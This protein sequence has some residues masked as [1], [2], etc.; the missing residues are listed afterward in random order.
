MSI[1]ESKPRRMEQPYI[2]EGIKTGSDGSHNSLTQHNAKA[3]KQNKTT[4]RHNQYLATSTI[5]M[6]M[7]SDSNIASGSAVDLEKQDFIHESTKTPFQL[8]IDPI[9]RLI[10]QGHSVEVDEPSHQITPMKYSQQALKGASIKDYRL[11]GRE[12]CFCEGTLCN[13]K[14][15]ASS[16]C[17][18]FILLLGV[19]V[20]LSIATIML[21]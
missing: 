14:C 18:G 21:F 10:I 17:Q 13:C 6:A 15:R 5:A 9:S 3:R 16:I 7:H 2:R 12:D 20:V 4:K 8:N 11:S 1:N 19:I